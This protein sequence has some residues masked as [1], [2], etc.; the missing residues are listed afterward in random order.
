MSKL[1]ILASP[2]FHNK[3]LLE[4]MLDLYLYEDDDLTLV[5]YNHSR[6]GPEAWSNVWAVEH[7]V[8]VNFHDMRWERMPDFRDEMMLRCHTDLICDADE[9]LIF[10]D[11]DEGWFERCATIAEGQQKTQVTLISNEDVECEIYD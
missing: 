9:L 5:T 11:G 3:R 6:W 7:G 1:A 10:W 2:D 4:G 8:D